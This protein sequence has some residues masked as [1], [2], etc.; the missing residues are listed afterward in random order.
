VPYQVFPTMDSF[1]MLS[2]GNDTQFAVLCSPAVLNRPE[3]ASDGRFS[4]NVRR[5]EHRS[6]MVKL[7]EEVLA[8]K[9]TGEWC[10]RLT[11]KG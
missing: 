1:I 8:E 7:I 5:V 2:A 10:E 3:W 4:T 6:E 9:T 11:G